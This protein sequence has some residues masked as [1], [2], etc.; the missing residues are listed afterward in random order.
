MNNLIK[1]E[2][3]GKIV[4]A[5][6]HGSQT[7]EMIPN[8]PAE[9]QSVLRAGNAPKVETLTDAELEEIVLMQIA[10]GLTLLGHKNHL[11]DPADQAALTRA[12]AKIIRQKYQYRTTAEIEIIFTMGV[13]G[14]LK[15]RAD[16]VVFLNI[17]QINSWFRLFREKVKPRA[18]E[19]VRELKE[20][21]TG[22]EI[23]FAEWRER[24]PEAAKQWDSNIAKLADKSK[25]QKAQ[26]AEEKP[27]RKPFN[28]SEYQ[29]RIERSLPQMPTAKLKKF[30]IELYDAPP[31][32]D[33]EQNEQ[34]NQAAAPII[35]LVRA[36]L[37]KR[38]AKK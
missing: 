1:T 18:M 28:E 14:E 16:E 13:C 36:E 3:P 22:T 38:N 7:F 6:A 29:A 23:S 15:T 27:E 10:S 33:A 20:P 2:Q 11:A 17:D 4:L 32:L 26:A 30:L 35:V 34:P 19:Y 9:V 25:Q 12:V 5:T 21:E 31:Y 37:E 8:T 24:N